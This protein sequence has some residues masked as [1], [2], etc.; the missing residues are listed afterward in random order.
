ME[1]NAK[2]NARRHFLRT[3]AVGAWSAILAACSPAPAGMVEETQVP[4]SPPATPITQTEVEAQPA[5]NTAQPAASPT[6]QTSPSPEAPVST[7]DPNRGFTPTDPAMV[8]L[9][10]GKPQLIEFFA[11]W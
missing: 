1:R 9:V 8:N 10:S 2:I 7:L 3:A 11:Y 4:E 6:V 5:A